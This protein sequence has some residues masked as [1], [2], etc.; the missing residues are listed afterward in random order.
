M[1]KDIEPTEEPAA[2]EGAEAVLP[3]QETPAE[4]SDVEAHGSTVSLAACASED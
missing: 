1:S 4:E 2:E 3:L